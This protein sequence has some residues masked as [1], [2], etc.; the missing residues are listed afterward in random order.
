M[1]EIL[2]LPLFSAVIETTS[3]EDAEGSFKFQTGEPPVAVSLAGIAFT[4]QLRTTA[5]SPVV[6]LSGSTVDGR[7]AVSGA[8]NEFL[9]IHVLA[10]VMAKLPPADYTFDIVASADG[11]Q[12][13]VIFGDWRHR[14]GVTR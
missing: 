7:L 8:S 11:H 5:P 4:M 10:A 6:A 14:L 13:R 3:N 9:V 2:N 1:T 12:R